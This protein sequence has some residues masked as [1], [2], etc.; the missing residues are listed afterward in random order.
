MAGS[1]CTAEANA[2]L[3]AKFK[4]ATNYGVLLTASPTDAGT[5]TNEVA[6]AAAYARTVTAFVTDGTA[7]AIANTSDLTFPAA[8]GG[9]WGTVTHLAFALS[10]TWNEIIFAW[11]PLTTS[12]LIEDGDQ[13]K[14]VTGNI[15][16]TFAAGTE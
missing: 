3:T 9:D 14:F 12:K 7:R 13:I 8:S 1:F 5:L 2:I 11:G 4:T 6:N 10:S 15:T 16:I